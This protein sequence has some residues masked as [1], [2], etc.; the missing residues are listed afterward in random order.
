MSKGTRR[1]RELVELLQK[2]GMAT[3]RPATVR[4][5][6]N[7]IFG[8]FDVLAVSPNHPCVYAIQVKSNRATGI[9]K[10]TSHTQLFRNLGWITM[11]AVPVDNKGWRLIECTKMGTIDVI[12]ERET[13]EKVGEGILTHFRK[14]RK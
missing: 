9:R 4:Y 11:Y 12:D 6:E 2:A 14:Q 5:G 7:D 3:Y 1:E 10:W 8:L 13:N